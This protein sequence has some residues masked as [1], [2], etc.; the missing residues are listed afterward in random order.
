MLRS[1]TL[2]LRFKSAGG[3]NANAAKQLR[4]ATKPRFCTTAAAAQQSTGAA[5]ESVTGSP[6]V[7]QVHVGHRVRGVASIPLPVAENK[8]VEFA[9]Y[10]ETSLGTLLKNIREEGEQLQEVTALTVGGE[11]ISHCTLM[12]TLLDEKFV[13]QLDDKK[14][15]LLPNKAFDD[16]AL[17]NIEVLT[18]IR[19]GISVAIRQRLKSDPRIHMPYDEYVELCDTFGLDPSEAHQLCDALHLAGDVLH[20]K[21]NPQLKQTLFIRPAEVFQI[22]N[23]DVFSQLISKNQAHLQAELTQLEEQ[24]NPLDEFKNT[25][26]RKAL[27]HA[28]LIKFLGMTYLTVQFGV[29]A[30]FVW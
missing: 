10:P 28:N 26:D 7:S 5:T 11:R 27:N 12:E 15:E 14:I 4:I 9:V 8:T 20:Y 2:F 25:L 1:Q 18:L 6:G 3:R 29:L 30:R 13:I 23:K 24:F 19:Q 17:G 16:T 22:L 21:D